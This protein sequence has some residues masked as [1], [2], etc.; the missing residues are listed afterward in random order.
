MLIKALDSANET[1][2][3]ELENWISKKDFDPSEKVKAVIGLYNQIGVREVSEKKM[4]EYYNEGLA[5]LS[6]V[7]LPEARKDTLRSFA[8]F[9]M[10]R[11]L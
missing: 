1:Q 10:E 3:K 4:E 6:A 2:R 11:E 5:N 9:L 7:K 8:E